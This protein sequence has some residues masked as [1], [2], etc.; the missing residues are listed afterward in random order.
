MSLFLY[1]G[2]PLVMQEAARKMG[3]QPGKP[4]GYDSLYAKYATSE[5]TNFD[6]NARDSFHRPSSD[7]CVG[8]VMSR[9]APSSVQS[10]NS[11]V[12]LPHFK[13]S[14][15][16]LKM[17]ENPGIHST[18][19]DNSFR[20]SSN[21]PSLPSSK[22]DLFAGIERFL[23]S[24]GPSIDNKSTLQK[25]VSLPKLRQE[26][27]TLRKVSS[28][29][30]ES[31]SYDKRVDTVKPQMSASAEGRKKSDGFD[32]AKLRQAMDYANK[33]TLQIN[34]ENLMNSE[35]VT[36]GPGLKSVQANHSDGK[37]RNAKRKKCREKPKGK[38]KSNSLK[39][40]RQT[41]TSNTKN[42]KRDQLRGG[43]RKSMRGKTSRE[44]TLDNMA[45]LV[46]NF[47]KGLMLQELKAQL[48]ESQES[49]NASN[50]FISQSMSMFT[51]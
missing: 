9:P 27:S 43:D 5:E 21:G 42:G 3:V 19:T 2:A 49:M 28:G 37:F 22:S 10:M 16:S 48:L 6:G 1:N 45:S 38:R 12:K 23:G 18:S 44:D 33:F 41:G 32:Y 36:K 11:P 26:L 24:K 46:E 7:I 4:E 25:G 8:P 47:E 29:I 20:Y 30:G 31:T 40:Y 39:C 50:Q 17:T 13:K 14:Q 15:D 35:S 51:K 34:E